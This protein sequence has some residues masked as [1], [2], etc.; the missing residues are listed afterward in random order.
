M[1]TMGWRLAAVGGMAAVLTVGV[2]ISQVATIGD[3]APMSSAS[4]AEILQGAASH[5][6]SQPALKVGDNQFIYVSS[7]STTRQLPQGEGSDPGAGTV[8]A[9]QRQIWLS[10]DG[11][12][13]GVLRE[14]PKSGVGSWT[15]M[16]LPGC[17]NGISINTKGG[18]TFRQPC[19]PNANYRGDLPTDPK[20]MLALLYKLGTG[21]K[22]PRDQEAFTA[23]GDLILQAYLAPSALA[24]VFGALAKIPG[25]TVVG[26]VADEAGRTGVAI[27][28]TDVQ[29]ARTELIFDRQSHAFLGERQVEV[30]TQDGLKAGQVLYSMAQLQVAVVD[31]VGQTS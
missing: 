6:Q 18:K 24:A 30:K 9:R 23:A 25:T 26:N 31:E 28:M 20:T 5:A 10:V 21:T 14:R 7:V 11:T 4:A 16:P 22:N 29:G 2:L 15:N 19:T 1:P 8:S 17:R 13:D 12:R 27:A 3:K